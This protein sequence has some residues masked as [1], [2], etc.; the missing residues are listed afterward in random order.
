MIDQFVE[1]AKK[2]I[3]QSLQTKFQLNETQIA[4]MFRITK[5]NLQDQ[6]K[7][8]VF[9]GKINDVLSIFT[10]SR[11]NSPIIDEVNKKLGIAFSQQLS[12]SSDQSQQI[13]NFLLPEIVGFFRTK[14]NQSGESKDIKGLS[15][16]LGLGHLGTIFSKFK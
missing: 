4:Q 12:F 9:K 16:F 13:V 1:E 8:F 3:G 5:S 6:I 11:D 15:K 2:E 10:Q 14:F 7:V